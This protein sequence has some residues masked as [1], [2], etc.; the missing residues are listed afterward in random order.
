MKIVKTKLNYLKSYLLFDV[1]SVEVGDTVP[2]DIFINKDKDYV[3]IIEAGTLL[4]ESLY[5]KLKKQEKLYML[6]KDKDKQILT[7]ETLKYY[8]RYNRENTDKRVKLLY[9]IANE[10]FDMYL[11]NKDDKFDSNCANLIVQS[12]I[13]LIK[14]DENFMKKTLPF[15]LNDNKLSTHSIHVAIYAVK[16]GVQLNFTKEKLTQ[17]GI[18]ALLHDV[19]YKKIDKMIIDKKNKLTPQETK[20]IRKHSQY[21]VDIVKKNHIHDPYILDAIIHHHERYDGSGYPEGLQSDE[22]SD[23]ASILAI[24]D[25]FDALTNNRPHRKEYSSFDALKMMIKDTSMMNKFNQKYLM[26]GLKSIT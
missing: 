10:F 8:I 11:S 24:C 14:Y 3:I 7:C 6:S 12:I 17:V 20:E 22:I 23:F 5:T 21:S 2:F 4:S 25:V 1:N 15:L 9:E 19:G 16:L 26:L 13:Y 18:A